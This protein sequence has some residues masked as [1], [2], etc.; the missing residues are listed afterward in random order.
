MNYF[1]FFLLLLGFNAFSQTENYEPER[2]I[3]N[4]VE[5]PY[6]YH[7]ME[8]YFNYY[9]EKRPV[10]NTDSTIINRNYVAVFEV[11][12][13]KFYL[14]DLFIAKKGQK[15]KNRSVMYKLNSKKEP[16]FLSWISGLYDIGIGEEQFLKNDTLNPYYNN[17]IVF[18]VAKGQIGRVERFSYNEMKRFKDYQYQRFK[19]TE[20]YDKLLRRL[21]YSGMS[22]FEAHAHIRQ[23]ILFYSKTNF[24]RK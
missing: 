19:E 5:Y 20:A 13:Q 3:W 17:Y 21:M 23:Y 4:G 18:E 10:A 24:L 11:K 12:D 15:T 16:M 6:R 8:Q 7:H 2:I 22:N 9:P 14:N 1:Y